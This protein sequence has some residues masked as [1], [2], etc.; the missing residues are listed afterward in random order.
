VVLTIAGFDPSGGAGIIADI[1]TLMAFGCRPV[2]AITSLTFQNSKALFGSIHQTADSLRAQILP[3]VEEF[4]IAAVKIGMLPTQDLVLET[5]RLVRETELPAPVVDPVLHSSSGYELME[6]AA[7]DVWLTELMPLAR[8]ITPNIP[9][10]EALT[11]MPIKN[12]SDML[13]AAAKLRE[14]GARAV[15]VKG[16]HLPALLAEAIDV[17]DHDGAVTV[18][19]GERIDGPPVRGTGCMLSSAIAAGLARDM[20]LQ[21]S[22]SAAKR[23]VAAVIRCAPDRETGSGHA[24]G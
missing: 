3:L 24:E 19:R 14:T 22:V 10:A 18:L 5:A 16:G 23:F 2:A 7:R 12:E 4:R 8:L 21:E 11:G 13:A 20:N 15:L 17:L 6:P 1:R 9:E